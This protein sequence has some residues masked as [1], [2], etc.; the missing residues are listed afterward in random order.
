VISFSRYRNRRQLAYLAP[1][2]GCQIFLGTTYQNGEK[3][4]KLPQNEPKGHKI[5]L[6]DTNIPN[7]NNIYQQFPLEGPPKF[8]QIDILGLKIFHL[9]SLRH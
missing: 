7:G 8:S 1:E 5:Y 6:F 2:P 3:Y 4:T 9:A